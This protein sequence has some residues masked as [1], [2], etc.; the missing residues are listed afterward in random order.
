MVAEKKTGVTFAQ[1]MKDLQKGSF[2]PIY[3]LSG[4]ESYFIDRIT[5]YILTHALPEDQRDFNQTV[6]FGA[7]V[8]GGQVADLARRYPMMAERQVVIVK[9]SQA[10]K[11]GLAYMEKYFEKPSPSTVLVCC[12][13][14]G[15]IDKRKRMYTLAQKN[16]AVLF[17]SKKLYDRELP[18]FIETYLKGKGATIEPK[19]A[20][21]M[22]DHVGSDLSRLV[23]ELD[24]ILISL[25]EDNRRVTPEIVEREVGVSKEFNAFELRSAIVNGD[26]FKANQIVKYFDKNPK[27]GGLFR[28]LP[29]LFSFFETLMIAYYAPDKN[30]D[31][32]LARFLDL[33]SSWAAKEYKIGMRNYTGV[34]VMQIIRKIREVDAKSKGIN[35]PST[36]ANELMQELIFFILH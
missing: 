20:Q 3:I 30:N 1:V 26:V 29:L 27:A 31:S 11:S 10:M 5:D 25:S 32:E 9:E 6:V 2:A 18:G 8:T 16:G 4:D 36:D 12:H 13:K 35:N 22:A 34:K 23:S 33:R 28:L 21:M 17:E 24:K 14:N 7:D 15:A 19:A